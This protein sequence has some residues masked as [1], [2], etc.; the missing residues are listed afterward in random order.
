MIQTDD[1]EGWVLEE[2]IISDTTSAAST[3]AASSAVRSAGVAASRTLSSVA[4]AATEM[5][6]RF[7][8]RQAEANSTAGEDNIT[9][10]YDDGELWPGYSSWDDG[11]SSD[12]RWTAIGVLI[13]VVIAVWLPW[14]VVTMRVSQI[15]D[16]MHI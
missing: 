15:Y 9:S 1:D 11:Y 4:S 5:A 10:K 2:E 6:T 7:V 3:A 16:S 13:G 12:L 14:F 8:R